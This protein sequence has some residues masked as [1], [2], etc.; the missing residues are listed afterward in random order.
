MARFPFKYYIALRNDLIA[1][2]NETRRRQLRVAADTE[3][4]DF[5]AAMGVKPR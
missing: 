5:D 2:N 1:E 4:V 3:D